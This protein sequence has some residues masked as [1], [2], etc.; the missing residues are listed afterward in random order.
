VDIL[1][2][3]GLWTCTAGAVEGGGRKVK[4]IGSG[5]TKVIGGLLLALLGLWGR[6]AAA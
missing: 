5:F 2:G 3:T 6:H 4:V 1:D